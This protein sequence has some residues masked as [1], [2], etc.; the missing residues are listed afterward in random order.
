MRLLVDEVRQT[1]V[2]VTGRDAVDS[3][4]VAPLIRQGAGHVN[5]AGLGHVVGRLLLRVVGNVARHGGSDDERA[6]ALLLEVGTDG[7]GAVGGAVEVDLN[8]LVPG[9]RGAINDARVGSGASTG[10]V[11]V[12]S[13][14]SMEE[15]KSKALTWQ[16]SRQSCQ[17]P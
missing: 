1:G 8:D 7:L 14:H 9:L 16:R 10:R 4:K 2:D 3:G 6:V 11:S 12:R 13:V 17:S 5:A 15:R